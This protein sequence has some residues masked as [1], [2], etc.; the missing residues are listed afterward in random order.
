MVKVLFIY[1]DIRKDI[2]RYSG[3][4][5]S[6][7]GVL[8]AC[9]KKHGQQVSLFHVTREISFEE[10]KG[11]VT[12]YQPALVAF[13]S[14]TNMF[15]YVKEWS[16]WVK[17]FSNIPTICGGIHPTVDPEDSIST[18]GLDM[19]CLGEGEKAIVELAER[20]TNGQNYCEIQSTW[21]R[22]NG[23][24]AKNKVAPLREDLDSLP[25]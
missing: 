13:S 16:A 4:Y 6:G 15:P 7:I 11:K 18:D 22:K 17:K 24:I 1:P 5:S 3:K 19:I 8:S 9:L 25:F 2:P 14:M 10:L 12:S 23:R 21:I 20:I